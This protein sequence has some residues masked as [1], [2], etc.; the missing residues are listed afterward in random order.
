[1]GLML[2]GEGTILLAAVMIILSNLAFNVGESLNSAFLPELAREEAIG[3][4]SGWGWSFGYCGGIV[5]LGLC[6]AVVVL[7][8]SVGLTQN[9]VIDGT[10]FVTALVFALAAAPIFLFVKERSRPRLSI[11][12]REAVRS[13]CAES[14]SE[15]L[16]T[17]K[18]LPVF[19][20]FAWLAVCGFCYQCGV[21]VVITLSA[22]YAAAVMGFST[23]ETLV[24]VFLVNIT[25]A[26][27]AFAFGYVQDR[28]GHK[29]A[30]GGTLLVWLSMIAV[31]YLSTEEW[32]FWI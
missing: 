6:L 21:S 13:L 26:V 3:K 4:V 22:V 15:V 2:T 31:A 12:D 16:T 19:R 1:M 14:F 17:L 30:L 5:T 23:T 27:G 8:P 25:A 29:L 20:D 9:Q 10:M 11:N 24:M 32:H 7:G 18:A 28:I